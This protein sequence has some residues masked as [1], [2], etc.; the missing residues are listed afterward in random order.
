MVL[1][2]SRGR[3]LLELRVCCVWRMRTGESEEFWARA[4]VAYNDDCGFYVCMHETCV[5]TV[6]AIVPCPSKGRS[7]RVEH[8]VSYQMIRY[9]LYSKTSTC[10]AGANPNA[11]P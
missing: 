10:Q 5:N 3:V 7:S 6:P 9:N 11:R 2:P 8:V 1:T 4:G